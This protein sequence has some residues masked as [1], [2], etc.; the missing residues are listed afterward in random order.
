MAKNQ[1]FAVEIGNAWALHRKGQN[2]D[3]IRAFKGILETSGSNTVKVDVLYGLGLAQRAAGHTEAA[4][5]SLQQAMMEVNGARET[6]PR[7]DR[8]LMLQRMVK[9]RIDEIKE[10]Q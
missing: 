2:E 1:E 10:K 8:H 6:F 5:S 7:E 3:A 9:Q 4:M